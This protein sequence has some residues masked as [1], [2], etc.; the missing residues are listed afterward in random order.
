[1][2]CENGSCEKQEEITEMT[3][4][5]CDGINVLTWLVND[6]MLAALYITDRDTDTT[7]IIRIPEQ[8]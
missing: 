1:M 7:L 3:F 6:L 5:F 8:T 4:Y 2:R